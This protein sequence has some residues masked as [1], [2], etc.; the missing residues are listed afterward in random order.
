MAHERTV[1][2]KSEPSFGDL[3]AGG[4]EMGA[5]MRSMDVLYAFPSILLAI[6]ICGILGSGLG[7]TILALTVTFI[8]PMVRISESVTGTP[9][10]AACHAASLPARPPPIIRT[11][12]SAPSCARRT[13]A[14]LWPSRVERPRAFSSP[15]PRRLAPS[16]DWAGNGCEPCRAWHRTARASHAAARPQPSRRRARSRQ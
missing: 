11:A 9:C 13:C 1:G 7:N 16:L 15:V 2:S 4:G 5:I 6:A 8:P 10:D 12:I 14:W 3:F